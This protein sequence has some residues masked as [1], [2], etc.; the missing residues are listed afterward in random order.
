V[1]FSGA[2]DITA[3]GTNGAAE[4]AALLAELPGEFFTAGD[5]SN[6][7]GL[8]E[9]YTS[10]FSPTWGQFMDRLH[11]SPGNHDYTYDSGAA[12]YAYFGAAAGEAGKGYYSFDE[13]A[14]HVVMLNSNCNYVDCGEQSQQV[15]WLAEDLA[16][17]P[18]RCTLAIW[19]HPRFSSGLAGSNGLYPFWQALYDHGADLVINGN[20]HDYERFAPQDPLGNAD[21]ER[22]IREFV[23]GTGGAGQR[24]FANEVQPNSE[25]RNTGTFGVLKLTLYAER[26]DWE[27]IP[28]A[29][30]EFRDSGSGECH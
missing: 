11:P 18:N 28:V 21:P 2:G 14:W 24:G 8:M 25:A 6:D 5:N 29:G 17:H 15:Q 27:F 4:T 13:G 1:V 19:H 23:V 7:H 26:Y 12:Y 16:A 10:C 9:Q 30:G 22:G 3:C 20:D